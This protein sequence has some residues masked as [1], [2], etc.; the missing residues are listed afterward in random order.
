MC[1]PQEEY[2]RRPIV[3]AERL[4]HWLCDEYHQLARAVTVSSCTHFFPGLAALF[5]ISSRHGCPCMGH[6]GTAP[7]ATPRPPRPPPRALLERPVA[8]PAAAPRPPAAPL[9]IPQ[10]ESVSAQWRNISTDACMMR[11]QL[12]TVTSMPAAPEETSTA[13]GFD[14]HQRRLNDVTIT[15]PDATRTCPV[16]ASPR[17][18]LAVRVCRAGCRGC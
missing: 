17:R 13:A 14:K 18:V 6:S 2:Q 4:S 3:K 11:W 10:A 8:R 12:L 1:A 15:A 5:E 9:Q 16:F 7:D